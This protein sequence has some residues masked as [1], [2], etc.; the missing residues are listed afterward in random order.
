MQSVNILH[1]YFDT[2]FLY[3]IINLYQTLLGNL[4]PV[5]C[6]NLKNNKEG[7]KQW[8]YEL[9]LDVYASMSLWKT[10][11]ILPLITLVLK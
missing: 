1:K 10:M 5:F 6:L 11:W 7:N 4:F 3:S 9:R 2:T 8:C